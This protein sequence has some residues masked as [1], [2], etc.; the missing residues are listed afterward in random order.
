M[1]DGGKVV[2]GAVVLSALTVG[3]AALVSRRSEKKRE[4]MAAGSPVE[5]ALAAG[6]T[7]VRAPEEPPKKAL[8]PLG[9][10]PQSPQ[11]RNALSVTASVSPPV[12]TPAV[13]QGPSA[14]TFAPAVLP[15]KQELPG[16]EALVPVAKTIAAVS[17]AVF[18]KEAEVTAAAGV[19]KNLASGIFSG[20]IKPEIKRAL[21]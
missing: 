11:I 13:V 16:L 10:S 8:A 9:S 5:R 6:V 21:I 17:P 19:L 7:E 12:V 15:Q 1:T 14:V 2:L 3:G 20:G 4:K 18:R